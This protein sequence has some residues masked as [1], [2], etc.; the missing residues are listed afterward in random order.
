MNLYVTCNS[1]EETV[2]IKSSAST[3]P[4]LQMEKGEEFTV[5]C[6]ESGKIVKVHVNDVIAEVNKVIIIIGLVLGVIAT[7]FLWN[8]FGAISTVSGIIPILFWQQEIR[9]VK[10]FNSFMI[11]RK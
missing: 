3:R 6:T 9:A 8:Y 10:S 7:V 11:R 1:C 2:R 4:D 5:N